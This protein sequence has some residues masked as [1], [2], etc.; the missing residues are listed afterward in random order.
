M[1][2]HTSDVSQPD[3][4]WANAYID[5]D[6]RLR[7]LTDVRR[8]SYGPPP[9]PRAPRHVTDAAS[10]KGRRLIL[11]KADGPVYDVRAA[12][13]VWSDDAGQWIAVV[14]EWRWYAWVQADLESRPAS[15]PR[16]VAHPVV[17]VWVET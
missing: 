12:S 17:N 5:D 1:T 16:S 2:M 14:E 15:C 6:G 10:V 13:E 11:M 7:D 3:D 8:K 9:P 4:P